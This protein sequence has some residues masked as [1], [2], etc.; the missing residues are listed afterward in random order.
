M[1]KPIDKD[2]FASR[3]AANYDSPIPSREF[4]LQLLEE[5]P[6]PL[7][8]DELA[9]ALALGDDEQQREALRRRV[10]AML[11][12]G[13]LSRNKKGGLQ[14]LDAADLVTGRV[15]ANPNGFGFVVPDEGGDDLYLAFYEMRKVFD[16]DRVRVRNISH[17]ASK[18]E[19]EIV[20][21][22]ERNTHKV[23]GK[24]FIEDGK[25]R[26]VPESPKISHTVFI[27]A[28]SPMVVEHEQIVLVEI[29]QQP[30]GRRPPKGIVVQ[31]LGNEMDPGMEIQIAV[32]NFG[33]P[34]EWPAAVDE[35]VA[36]FA[37]EP[38]EAE[39]S[40]RVDLRQLPLV[41]IDGEDA[42]DFD[43]AIH[44]RREQDG[45]RLWVAIADVSHYVAVDSP[46]DGEAANRGTSVYFPEQVIPMLPEKLSNGLCSLKPS[47]D[48]LCMVCEM[49]ISRHGELSDYRFY[50]AVMHSHA[51]L[52]YTEV[53]RMLLEKDDADSP[54][55]Q[56]YHHLLPHIDELH[57]LYKA[58]RKQREKRGAMDFETTETR[59]IF[60]EQRKIDSI[61]PVVRNDAHKIVEE[62]MLSANVAT[63]LLLEQLKLPILFRVHQGPTELRLQSLRAFLAELGLSMGGGDAPQPAD[64]Q[65]LTAEVEGRADAHVIQ[66]M[67][68]RSMSQAVYQ[69]ENLGHFGLAYPAYAHFTS[70]IRRYPDLL[71]HRAIRFALRSG[72]QSPHLHRPDQAAAGGKQHYPYDMPRMVQLGEHCSMA[73]RRAD[74]ATRDVMSWLKCEYLLEHLGSEF[75]AVITGVASFGFFAELSELYVEGMVHVSELG[76]DYFVFDAAKQ[77]LI[78]EHSRRIY[79]LGDVVRVKVS[80]I[81]MESRKIHLGLVGGLPA[82]KSRNK[83]ER[84]SP[85]DGKAGKGGKGGKDGGKKSRSRKRR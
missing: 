75:D 34:H 37:D 22:I 45:W 83:D 25:Q 58:L 74:D 61:V 17:T 9:D 40:G 31:V 35:Q 51:R 49:H 53:G 59:V 14:K 76:D 11:R 66:T 81:E 79:H 42:R 71:V 15:V 26:V 72:R 1:T 77:R 82:R 60:N 39:K 5:K 44:C 29:T 52:T 84:G 30:D 64:Y 13:Q 36:A 27:D 57:A 32:H 54:L 50:E 69:P 63:A 20:E 8:L 23:V 55:R 28:D 68:L 47:V 2:P 67:L 19:A 65:K 12:D 4:I 48:R 73:E 78:G 18:S 56:H 24:L 10:K 6:S 16:G 85:A 70:P 80:R 38:A 43:D 33:I 62:C 7:N 46:L 41:T 21:V 3:E